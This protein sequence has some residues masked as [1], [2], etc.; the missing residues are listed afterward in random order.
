MF[1]PASPLTVPLIIILNFGTTVPILHTGMCFCY[2]LNSNS[3]SASV[4]EK[5]MS[6]A[7][8]KTDAEDDEDMATS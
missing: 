8:R 6:K 1:S 3:T 7:P 2:F 5:Y 4:Q